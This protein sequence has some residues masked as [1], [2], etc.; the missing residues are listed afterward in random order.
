S[1]DASL[2]SEPKPNRPHPASTKNA[3]TRTLGPRRRRLVL[4]MRGEMRLMR[5][6][7]HLGDQRTVIACLARDVAVAAHEL[8]EIDV[9]AH[10]DRIER[11]HRAPRRER[12][13]AAIDAAEPRGPQE[14]AEPAVDV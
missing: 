4:V 5:L 14:L 11:A 3:A 9:A 13:R 12:E 8:D 2:G 1:T 7:P 10:E 6:Q